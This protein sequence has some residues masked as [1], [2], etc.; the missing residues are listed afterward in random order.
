MMQECIKIM[1]SHF[2]KEK[3]SATYYIVNKFE[4]ILF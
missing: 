2:T 4:A 1:F 3:N